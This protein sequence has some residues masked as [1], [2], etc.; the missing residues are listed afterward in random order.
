M[1]LLCLQSCI[2]DD[3]SDCISRLRIELEWIQTQ[4]HDNQE[5]VQLTITPT[6]FDRAEIDLTSDIYGRDVELRPDMY[7][8]VGWEPADNITITGDTVTLATDANTYALI[9]QS[10]SGGATEAEVYASRGDQVIPLPMRRQTRPLCVKVYFTGEGAADVEGLQAQLEGVTLERNIDDAFPPA[11]GRVR[12]PAYRNG[13]AYYTFGW[14]D[15]GYWFTTQR[16]IGVDGDAAQKLNFTVFFDGGY[17]DTIT[18]DVTGDM[19]GY[20]TEDVE[21]PWCIT[22]TMDLTEILILTITDWYAGADDR[23]RSPDRRASG[24]GR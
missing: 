23:Q 1:G 12:P 5:Q 10:F 3:L 19:V 13:S 15:A 18:L 4:P 6:D 7:R 9:P 22:V 11:S 21:N 20:H 2:K 8:I 24:G 17:S 16:L 14:Q